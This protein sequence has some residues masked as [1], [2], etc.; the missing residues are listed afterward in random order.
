MVVTGF[1]AET[2]VD[3]C[4]EESCIVVIYLLFENLERFPQVLR[5]EVAYFFFEWIL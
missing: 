1:G 2:A 3:T 4:I 5:F